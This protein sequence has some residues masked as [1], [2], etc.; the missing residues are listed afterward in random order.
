MITIKQET[1]TPEKARMYLNTNK[2]G[3]RKLSTKAV[4]ELARAIRDGKWQLTH[5]GIAFDAKGR[6]I[7]G[8]HRLN[9]VIFA[10]KP[11][12]MMVARGVDSSKNNLYTIDT[13]IKRSVSNIL[14]MGGYSPEY[15]DSHM[16]S[17]LNCF[18]AT[19]A[20]WRRKFTAEDVVAYIDE[21]KEMAKVL[22]G[23]VCVTR[24]GKKTK[25]CPAAVVAAAYSAFLSGEN[26]S[27][28]K[29]FLRCYTRNEIIDR[30]NSKSALDLGDYISRYELSIYEAECRAENS[31]FAYIHNVKKAAVNIERYKAKKTWFYPFEDAAKRE[32]T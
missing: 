21:N 29:N 12:E 28:V 13:G 27:D 30:Y 4:I 32:G 24:Y 1:I 2:D 18:F 20:N 8:Q 25:P 11:V 3:N 17:A 23:F 22:Y 16:V 15:K 10:R 6:L 14:D 26:E 19:K 7:D 9:A 5:Q 31:I